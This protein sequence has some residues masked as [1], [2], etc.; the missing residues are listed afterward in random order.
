LKDIDDFFLVL[1]IFI[2]SQLTFF[3][4]IHLLTLCSIEIEMNNLFQFAFFGA[5]M[6]SKKHFDIELMLDFT[7]KKN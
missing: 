6:M 2:L 3:F 4:S 5:V 7:K 1:W